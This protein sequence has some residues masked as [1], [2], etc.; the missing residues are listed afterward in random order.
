MTHNP[1][2]ISLSNTGSMGGGQQAA[3]GKNNSQ[4]MTSQTNVPAGQQL[5]Q[6]QVIQ[7]LAQIEDMIRSAKLPP[8][9]Q[10]KAIAYLSAAKMA[11]EEAEPNK[12]LVAT[13]LGGVAKTLNGV[14]Q[15]EGEGKTLWEKVK[16]ILLKVT[17][18]LGQA[19]AGS[20][21][22]ILFK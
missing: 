4:T 11:T 1:D 19:I 13:N 15:N 17:D 20:L 12:E 7:M 9:A 6:Q 22:G 18:W 3:T 2:G 21:L 14:S 16:P 8:D 10:K 5:T